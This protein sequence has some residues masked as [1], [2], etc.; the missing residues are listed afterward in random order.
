MAKI[1]YEKE[2][3]YFGQ[4]QLNVKLRLDHLAVLLFHPVETELLTVYHFFFSPPPTDLWNNG[5]YQPE[6][7]SIQQGTVTQEIPGCA[8]RRGHMLLSSWRWRSKEYMVWNVLNLPA[9]VEVLH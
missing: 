5:K 2:N 9:F 6:T 3:K 7:F 8:H 1:L 4:L